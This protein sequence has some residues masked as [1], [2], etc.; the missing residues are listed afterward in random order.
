MGLRY[1]IASLVLFG[2]LR[3]FRPIVNK[4]TILLSAFTWAAAGF[5]ALGLEYVSPSESAVLSYTMPLI[6]IP[7]SS[8]VLSEKASAKEWAGAVVGLCGVLVYS[9]TFVNQ[10][11]TTLG[12]LLT[13]LNAIFWA[14]YT[15][16]YRKLKDQNPT[17]TVATQ[18]FFAAL[19][20][21]LIA[22]LNYKMQ[23][24]PN[25][26]FDLLYLSVLSAALTFWLWNAMARL[27]R[28]GKMS[29][30]IYS[31]PVTVTAVQSVE[32]SLLPAPVS[33]IGIGLMILGLYVSR[34]EGAMVHNRI[35]RR[36]LSNPPIV[37]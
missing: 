18:L 15:T 31:I 10:K 22:P 4:D 25:L 21:F 26:L 16:Y 11:L 19:L 8:V 14:L 24:T 17:R 13:L 27:Q 28:I 34:A 2:L 9:L 37:E 12:A 32:T 7:I 1:L 36:L 33:L 23:P 29:T 5:W 3:S 6:S 30:L 35:R 20:F